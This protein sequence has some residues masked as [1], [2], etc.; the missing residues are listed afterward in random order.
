MKELVYCPDCKVEL[1]FDEHT[2]SYPCA[3][4]CNSWTYDYLRAYAR[5]KREAKSDALSV[6]RMLLEALE[7]GQGDSFTNEIEGNILREVIAG[8]EGK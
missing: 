2:S 7:N 3:N 4:C 6:C 8:A 1:D 5:G